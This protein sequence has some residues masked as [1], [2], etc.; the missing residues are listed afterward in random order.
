MKLQKR[1]ANISSAGL[2]AG[3]ALLGVAVLMEIAAAVFP[4]T[5]SAGA[6]L[7]SSGVSLASFF[8][9]GGVLFLIISVAIFVNVLKTAGAGK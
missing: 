5:T 4:T 6:S 1:T 2:K 3:Y 8:G 9:S 7:Q